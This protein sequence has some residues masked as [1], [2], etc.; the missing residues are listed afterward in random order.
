MPQWPQRRIIFYSTSIETLNV[1]KLTSFTYSNIIVTIK[2][3]KVT[4]SIICVQIVQLLFCIVQKM[5]HDSA[6]IVKLKHKTVQRSLQLIKNE[7]SSKYSCS[8]FSYFQLL[9][10]DYCYLLFIV[11]NMFVM[12]LFQVCSIISNCSLARSL[13][14]IEQQM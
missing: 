3:Y 12:S 2:V 9:M 1:S 6:E 7:F 14:F 4:S 8:Y 5:K 10:A 11:C 13:L